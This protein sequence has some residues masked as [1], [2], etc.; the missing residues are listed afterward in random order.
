VFNFNWVLEQ[1]NLIPST[2]TSP[3]HCGLLKYNIHDNIGLIDAWAHICVACD[4]NRVI[5]R[6]APQMNT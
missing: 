5:S 1:R 2:V 4:N 3:G 6:I